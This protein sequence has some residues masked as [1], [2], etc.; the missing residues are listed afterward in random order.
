MI[1]RRLSHSTIRTI[2]ISVGPKLFTLSQ[3]ALMAGLMLRA[4]P[5]TPPC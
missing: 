5:P 2:K 4:P 3:Y 1:P